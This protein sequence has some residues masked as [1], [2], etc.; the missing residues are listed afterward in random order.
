[1]GSTH[2]EETASETVV[3]KDQKEFHQDGIDPFQI[4]VVVERFQRVRGDGRDQPDE[5]V[6]T[7]H[8]HEARR[9]SLKEVVDRIHQWNDG[10][11]VEKQQEEQTEEIDSVD[12]G[13]DV[14]SEENDHATAD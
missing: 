7:R 8:Q 11:A 13:F 5:D 3:R 2:I 6:H 12:I 10:E 14:E 9:W 1:M 4:R